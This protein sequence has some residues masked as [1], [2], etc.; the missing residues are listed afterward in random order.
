MI[1]KL[2]IKSCELDM[3]SIN[4]MKIGC[5]TWNLAWRMKKG[6]QWGMKLH[7]G[8]KVGIKH[9]QVV[10]VPIEITIMNK[11]HKHLSFKLAWA[12]CVSSQLWTCLIV[13]LTHVIVGM[14][15]CKFLQMWRFFYAVS[16]IKWTRLQKTIGVKCGKEAARAKVVFVNE[17]L[18]AV[19]LLNTKT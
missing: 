4:F 13:E 3:G 7:F 10:F 12:F 16:F 17:A 8:L 15:M 1:I 6:F 2:S 5:V 11:P 19:M 18:V 9:F 14:F